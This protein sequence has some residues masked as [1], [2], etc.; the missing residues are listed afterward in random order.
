MSKEK[1]IIESMSSKGV[2]PLKVFPLKEPHVY[3]AVTKDPETGGLR[4]VIIEPTLSEK[5]TEVLNRIKEI[6]YETLDVD[7]HSFGS[8]Q[9]AEKYL[10]NAA[11]SIIESHKIELESGSIERLEYYLVRDLINYGKIDP[12][13]HDHMVEDASCDGPGTPIYVWHRQYESLPTNI[14]FEESE[15]DPFIVRLAYLVGKHISIASPM[16]D[17][18]LPDGSRIQLTYGREVTRKGSTFTIRR[19]RAEPL[20]VADLVSL[21]T[22]TSEMAA[23]FWLIMERKSNIIIGGGTASGKTTTLNSLSSFIPSDDKII[24]IED[25]AELNLPHKNWI[26]SVARFGFGAAGSSAEINLFDL[27]KAAMRQRPDYII[28]GEVRG[29]EAYTLFQAM[30]TGH[31]GLSSIHCDSVPA[32]FNRLESEPMNIPRTLL[33][34]VN[35]VGMQ[36]RVRIG[37]RVTRKMNHVVEVVGL[38]PVSKEILTNEVFRW[39]P[40]SDTFSNSGRS[41]V[42]EKIM[43]RHGLSEQYVENELK[44]RRIVLDWLTK[45]N[46][47][48]DQVGAVIRD[49]YN[50]PEKV[51]EKA[52]VGLST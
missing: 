5:E 33:T 13:M 16:L 19:F 43:E 48:F 42:L 2:F 15:L 40:K 45:S 18:S 36:N 30:A 41:I 38:D 20:T 47:R 44:N 4:Y 6:F 12:I 46:L 17:G 27:L 31:G 50:D 52:S 7:L 29:S 22:M 35:V 1:S 25:T 51:V 14:V 9:K 28:V 26:S 32:A 3:A 23:W 21:E 8:R 11:R 24:T 34:T 49:Y 10:R 37:D 39:D